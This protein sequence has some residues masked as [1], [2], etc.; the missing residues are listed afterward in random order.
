MWF[1]WVVLGCVAL[2]MAATW[3]IYS[4]AGEAGWKSLIPVLG[5]LVLLRITG[6]PWWWL[7]LLLVPVVN[8]YLAVVLCWDL[9]R[10]FNKG[11]GYAI[12]LLLILPIPLCMLAWGDATYRGPSRS[13]APPVH[14]RAA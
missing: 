4:K 13:V 7:L 8:L 10:V 1:M 11:N 6:R 9:A 14:A 3:T 2:L 5:A 12:A